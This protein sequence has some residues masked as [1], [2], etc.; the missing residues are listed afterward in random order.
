MNELDQYIKHK[1]KVEYYVRYMDDG[2][3]VLES[4]EK[5]KEYLAEIREFA[6]E[7]LKLELNKKTGYFPLKNGVIFC[8]FKIYTTHK[9][10]KRA[11]IQRMK[12]RIKYWNKNYKMADVD[13]IKSWKQSFYAWKGYANLAEKYNLY[14]KLENQCEWIDKKH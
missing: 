3:L 8:G 14:K 10:M 1:L 13:D 12:K 11:N 2:I 9:L 4:K 5:A 7:K 6:K